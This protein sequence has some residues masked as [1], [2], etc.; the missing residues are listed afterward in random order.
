MKYNFVRKMKSVLAL[1]VG[2]ALALSGMPVAAL[3]D[4]TRPASMTEQWFGK[5]TMRVTAADGSLSGDA[6][7][8]VF[9]DEKP[10]SFEGGS[11]AYSQG[12]QNMLLASI[13]DVLQSREGSNPLVLPARQADINAIQLSEGDY[14]IECIA[15]DGSLR[16]AFGLAVTPETFD[17]PEYGVP[18]SGP[19]QE[20]VGSS[21]SGSSS[22]FSSLESSSSES[23]FES[24]SSEPTGSGSTGSEVTSET[25]D[26]KPTAEE[27]TQE[28]PTE[29]T[30]TASAA[31]T[32]QATTEPTDTEPTITSSDDDLEPTTDETETEQKPTDEPLLETTDE[33]LIEKFIIE[34]DNALGGEEPPSALI[35]TLQMGADTFDE[36]EDEDP[37]IAY[38]AAFI[39]AL[40]CN[41]VTEL[42]NLLASGVTTIDLSGETVHANFG[43]TLSSGTLTIT[44]GTI[45][46]GEKNTGNILT[47]DGTGTTDGVSL[48]L[49]GTTMDGNKVQA[50]GSL[51]FV[52]GSKKGA[53]TLTLDASEDGERTVLKNN[54]NLTG[55]GGAV[56]VN[57]ATLNVDGGTDISDNT[58]KN[59]GGIATGG[60]TTKVNLGDV[61]IAGNH[62]VFNGGGISVSSANG[63]AVTFDP[64]K[65][66]VM[67]YEN[68][69]NGQGSDI[70]IEGGRFVL[71]NLEGWYEDGLSGG[72]YDEEHPENAKEIINTA[73]TTYLK[74]SYESPKQEPV[75]DPEPEPPVT[76]GGDDSRT[77]E[78]VPEVIVVPEPEKPQGNTPAGNG[79]NGDVIDSA[80]D[81]PVESPLLQVHNL[82][83][84]E[85]SDVPLGPYVALGVE[86]CMNYGE[87]IE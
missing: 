76:D 27:S 57:T 77:E 38:V 60:S 33:H 20:S 26:P 83:T 67:I 51:I 53:A 79:S 8:W 14:T 84:I 65:L 24:S 42:Q 18:L 16:H 55:N 66:N 15:A 82:V 32:G 6:T 56:N 30:D 69:A 87:S 59:G 45:I 28:V 40:E 46:R 81:V 36:S 43:F 22:D 21:D 54:V 2:L 80:N 34:L 5:Y 29:S 70:A 9:A 23:S 50:A 41:N 31:E 73:G 52:K 3:S 25:S 10:Q 19:E 11:M 44:G 61:T 74:N 86:M 49:R 47:V 39:D 68:S 4:A 7:V 13:A 58:A 72:R 71:N 12:T 35:Q 37:N 48:T 17:I 1:C 78:E 75:P 62:A 63:G 85:D 64:D